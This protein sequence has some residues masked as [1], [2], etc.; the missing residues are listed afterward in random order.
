MASFVRM[1]QE[2]PVAPVPVSW[3]EQDWAERLEK[4]IERGAN[5]L[6]S[7]QAEE[8][9]W[10][11]ELEA[12][13]T[14]E[15]DYIYYLYVLGKADPERI[16]KLANYVRRRQL[17][18]GGWSIYPGGPSELN[19]TCKAYF[20]LKLAG[21]STEARHLVQARETVHLLGG[22]EHT[23]SYVRFYLALIGA[24]GW[25]LVPSIPPEFMLLPNWF[26][27]NIYEMSSWTR[28]IVIPMAILS[29]LRPAWRLPERARVDEL[30]KDLTRKTAAFDWSTQL[31]SWK[32]VFLALDRGLKLYEKLPWKPLRQRA[33]REAKIWMLNHIE[34]TE[35]LAAIYPAMMNSIF[36]LMAL[37]HGPDDPLT[38]R[39]IK[40]FSRF[41]IEEGDTIR[42][43]PCVSPVWDTCIAMVALE[44]AGL[45]ADH[46]ALVK[47]ADWMLSKQ[48]LGPGDWQ[49]KN[50]DAE[51]GG[52]AFEFRNDF[53]PDVDDTAFVLMA[54]QRV[55]YPDPKRMEGAVRRGI[56]WLL[57]MQNRDGGWGAFDRDND[58]KFLC[59]IPFADHNAMIDPSTADVTARVIECLGRFGWPA[60]HPAIQRAVRFLLK[61]QSDDGSWFGRWGVNYVYGTSGVL[62]ALE[63]VSLTARDYCQRAVLWLRTMQKADGSFGESLR[64]Y[65]MPA[66]K[67]QGPST[68]SQTAWG[69]IG[70]LAGAD[71]HEPAIDKAVSYLVDQ[72]KEDGSWSE[73]DFTGTGFPGVFYLKYHFYRNSFPVYALAR[74]ANQ[75]CGAD[76]YVALKFQPSEF[77]LRR[78][79]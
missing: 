29:S 45:P 36:A 71:V 73:P 50:K 47:A 20:A 63:T 5:H 59:N 21:D 23:N 52:W 55:K 15:S 26:Y 19:A 61:D 66:T 74:Y 57:S 25:E 11:G 67:G 77:R 3:Q 13:T 8:G 32:N 56:Q 33:L 30:F 48:V 42:M 28:G 65:E 75:S 43:Q 38:W 68:P 58:K 7:M 64:S 37:G 12:D 34:R 41:E 17:A 10:Q 40:E 79:F 70:L 1:G 46:P 22:L 51:P 4:T 14:L 24:V 35:G 49:V 78:G 9:Y 6:L 2:I 60:E 18:D 27:F 72:Q 31:I 39:E 44:E 76:E 16:A 62:R 53:Y 69:L 54:L